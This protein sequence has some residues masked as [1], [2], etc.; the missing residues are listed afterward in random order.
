MKKG[1]VNW[2]ADLLIGFMGAV[3]LILLVFGL[4]HCI[5]AEK[6]A[7]INPVMDHINDK[8]ELLMMLRSPVEFDGSEVT[9]SQLYTRYYYNAQDRGKLKEFLQDEIQD[10]VDK[11]DKGDKC[12]NVF[13]KVD[14][15]EK[16]LDLWDHCGDQKF[17]EF[18][19]PTESAKLPL[20]S[21]SRNKYIEVFY[22]T[23]LKIKDNT[24][25]AG[26]RVLEDKP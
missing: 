7:K 10:F 5:R 8:E 9:F 19:K 25:V 18:D 6:Q 26:P 1:I 11:T 12:W 3:V 16:I 4:S 15:E 22:G 20:Y 23:D 17:K 2:A 14:G 21:L 24:W 13:V